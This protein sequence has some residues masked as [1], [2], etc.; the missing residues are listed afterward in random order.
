VSILKVDQEKNWLVIG[1]NFCLSIICW[2]ELSM[3]FS[4]RSV[5]D[6]YVKSG[7]SA[8][9]GMT[10]INSENKFGMIEEAYK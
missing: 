8:R 5:L 4:E 10:A 1:L 2:N 9:Y 6:S 7:T 3:S